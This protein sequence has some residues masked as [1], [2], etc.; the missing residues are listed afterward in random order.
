MPVA[1]D[2]HA[3]L[4]LLS[5]PSTAYAVRHDAGLGLR[6]V[7]WGAPIT[8]DEAK[9]LAEDVPDPAA[10]SYEQG[11]GTA[12]LPVEGG[13]RFGPPAMIVRFADGTRAIEWDLLDHEIDGEHLRVHLADRHYPLEATLH[14]RLA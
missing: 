3:R 10:S 9:A 1:F 11:A 2:P 6:H 14:Y 12:E 5:G 8:P 4:W 7:H 13:S